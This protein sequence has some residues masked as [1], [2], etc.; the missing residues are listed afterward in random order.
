MQRAARW[1]VGLQPDAT[2]TAACERLLAYLEAGLDR[3]RTK[4]T[5]RSYWTEVSRL[6]AWWGPRRLVD[7]T[8]A[9]VAA[10]VAELHRGGASTSTIRHLL[11]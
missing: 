7:T 5:M 4:R 10:Y 3:V 1:P 9:L 8:P 6:L 11:D 2:Y